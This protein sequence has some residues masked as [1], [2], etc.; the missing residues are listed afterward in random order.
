MAIA[1]LA[2]VLGFFSAGSAESSNG[3]YTP[4]RCDNC[5]SENDF[6]AEAINAGYG[7]FLVYNLPDG[8]MRYWHVPRQQPGNPGGGTRPM[9]SNAAPINRTPPQ[10]A[11]AELRAAREVY[12]IGGGTLRPTIN[13]P[14]AALG[15]NHNI[16]TKTAYDLVR[17]RNMQAMLESATGDIHVLTQVTNAD[18][19]TAFADLKSLAASLLGLKD[20]ASLVLRVVFSD[21]SYAHFRVSIDHPNGEYLAESARTAAGQ[22]IPSDISQ[23]QGEWS[24]Y[25]GENLE[26]IHRHF[27]RLGARMITIGAQTGT[28]TAISCATEG[29]HTVCRVTRVIY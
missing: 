23:V 10:E 4:I 26:S 13:V 25:G 8:T 3:F 6:Y 18:F 16:R 12:V 5:K 20:Q 27:E 15:V 7:H 28:S 29:N 2:G 19:M 17:D 1:A 21:G 24:N 9:A 11:T 22:F 14:V